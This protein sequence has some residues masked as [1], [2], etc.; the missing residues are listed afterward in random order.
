[1]VVGKK[2]HCSKLFTALLQPQK[3]AI[4]FGRETVVVAPIII[5]FPA[6]LYE[7]TFPGFDRMLSICGG[8]CKVNFLFVFYP[9]NEG[10]NNR[11]VGNDRHGSLLPTQRLKT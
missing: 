1:V 7:N 11:A 4:Y 6:I 2:H 8:K 9:E 5:L 3:K 10:K